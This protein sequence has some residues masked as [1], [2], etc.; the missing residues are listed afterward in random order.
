[1][2]G[3][4][5]DEYDFIL[6]VYQEIVKQLMNNSLEILTYMCER[7]LQKGSSYPYI[8]AET[9]EF[10]IEKNLH[11]SVEKSQFIK[12]ALIIYRNY[13][14]SLTLSSRTQSLLDHFKK[15]FEIFL[16]TDGNPILQKQKIEALELN[17]YFEEENIIITGLYSAAYHK[18]NVDS[19]NLLEINS[20]NALFFGDRDIDK[21]FAQNSSMQFQKVV[22][23]IGAE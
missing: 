23:M 20:K 16:I 2:D 9:Y 12:D 14:P 15:N 1:M 6:Q 17:N 19:L 8:F 10:A 22:N 21:I 5:Y 4:L 18:P 7:W 11:L 3:T 13:I